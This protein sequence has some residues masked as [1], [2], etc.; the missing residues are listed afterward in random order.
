M[1]DS[2]NSINA[3]TGQSLYDPEDL[4]NQTYRGYIGYTLTAGGRRMSACRLTRRLQSQFRWYSGMRQGSKSPPRTPYKTALHG[5]TGRARPNTLCRRL[6]VMPTEW[7]CGITIPRPRMSGPT[8]AAQLT[9]FTIRD[10]YLKNF[11]DVPLSEQHPLINYDVSY[12]DSMILPVAME[13]A[14]VPVPRQARHASGIRL[15][16][17]K[18]EAQDPASDRHAGS[19][20]APSRATNRQTA[21]DCILAAKATRSFIIPT[22]LSPRCLPAKM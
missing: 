2:N 20:Q 9:E 21:W 8:A 3:N 11:P 22:R 7:S 6:P 14:D 13:A 12:V 15:D 5:H 18:P 10:T 1:Q 16:R 4:Q 19:D 17:H